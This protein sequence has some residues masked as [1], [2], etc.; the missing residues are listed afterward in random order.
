MTATFQIQC[1]L[2]SKQYLLLWGRCVL[3]EKWSIAGPICFCKI[4]SRECR[5]TCIYACTHTASSYVLIYGK[6]LRL[7]VLH[8]CFA[9][10][11]S[12]GLLVKS[13][14]TWVYL[15]YF[16]FHIHGCYFIHDRFASILSWSVWAAVT[17]YY[18]RLGGLT[19]FISYSLKLRKIWDQGAVR[20]GVLLIMPPS[21][22]IF[23]YPNRVESREGGS[24]HSCPFWTKA[25]MQAPLS[26]PN[27]LSEAPSPNTIALEV[28]I[29]T[30]K[31][32]GATNIQSIADT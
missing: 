13:D 4:K 22:F 29:P 6:G 14:R 30:Y 1:L 9:V 3:L 17:N 12:W 31:L 19:T 24:K 15:I 32:Q 26:W 10:D 5:H 21:C 25:V 28:R 23:L 18:D 11:A 8:C 7:S 2:L 16:M 20:S 27:Y